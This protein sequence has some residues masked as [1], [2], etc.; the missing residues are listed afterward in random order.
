VNTFLVKHGIVEISHV[1]YS[2]H[3]TPMDFLYFL[4]WNLPSKERGFRM[5]K[6]LR[7]TWWPN[8]MLFLW[9][10]LLTVFKNFLNDAAVV[11]K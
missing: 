8:W 5:L 11:F 10:P 7:K 3:L 2:P 4:H 9:R 1:P 6:A